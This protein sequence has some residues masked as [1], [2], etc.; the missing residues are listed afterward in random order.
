MDISFGIWIILIF[1]FAYC[2]HHAV[3]HDHSWA[4]RSP[5]AE[6]RVKKTLIVCRDNAVRG[7]VTGW[8]AGGPPAAVQGMVLWTLFGGSMSGVSD[9]LGW[10][11]RLYR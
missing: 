3:C 11:T 8:L 9:I 1:I 5:S 7:A 4:A 10:D 6:S 2:M